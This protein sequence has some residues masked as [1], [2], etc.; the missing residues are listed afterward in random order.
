MLFLCCLMV[1]TLP[2]SFAEKTQAA[3]AQ[4][5]AEALRSLMQEADSKAD[6]LLVRYRLYPLTENEEVLEGL[7]E[8]DSSA[9]ARELALL[10]GLWAYRAGEA[11]VFRVVKYGRR[12]SSLLED[13]KAEDPDD[14]YVLL[15]ESQSL[16]FRPSIAGRNPDAAVDRLR[17]L[18]RHLKEG[19]Q[20]GI[21]RAEAQS[22]LWLALK[23]AGESDEA[24]RLY[25]RLMD[26]EVPPL[27]QEFLRNP[28]DV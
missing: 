18:L 5:D 17:K 9:S 3:Y 7:D 13:A 16:L 8:T 25:E 2:S 23:E 1:V 11:S 28:P 12:S 6:S 14:P 26:R 21:A 20:V 19:S 10:S 4:Q 15:V 27:Y 22:W 24:Q